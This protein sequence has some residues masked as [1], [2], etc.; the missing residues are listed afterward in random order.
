LDTYPFFLNSLFSLSLSF[1]YEL[2]LHSPMPLFCNKNLEH[3]FGGWETYQTCFC[4]S[5]LV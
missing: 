5:L 3:L 1:C 2:L 4:C